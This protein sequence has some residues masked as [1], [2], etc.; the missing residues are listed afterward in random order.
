[1]GCRQ[2]PFSRFR[3]RDADRRQSAGIADGAFSCQ[4]PVKLIK[5][6]RARGMKLIVI[7]PRFTETAPPSRRLPAA[8]TRRG[9]CGGHRPFEYNLLRGLD[10]D[11]SERHVTGVEL[12]R[13]AVGL[14]SPAYVEERAGIAPDSLIATA[15]AFARE[16]R[17]GFA[18][19]GTG[20]DMGPFSNLA[21]HLIE[22]LNVICGRF[23][24]VGDTVLENNP[25]TADRPRRAMAVSPLRSFEKAPK[26]RVRNTGMMFGEMM[27]G[28]MVDEMLL[29]G[30]GQL[31]S[32]LCFGGN[33]SAPCPR[34]SRQ[35]EHLPR[36][37][38]WSQWIPS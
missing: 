35:R 18:C 23:R 10:P 2:R 11:F 1:M 15:R 25:P 24:R 16:A 3:C 13:D 29:P 33:R 32:L 34:P 27:S 21:E 30:A 37:T 7:D 17:K 20:P 26:S 9:C 22:C 28:V 14:L 38:C 4:N 31:R 6:A 5:A 8:G 12:L 19:S 36:S